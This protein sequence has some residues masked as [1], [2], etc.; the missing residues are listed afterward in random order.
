MSQRRYNP[1]PWPAMFTLGLL[2]L[3]LPALGIS[4]A[5]TNEKSKAPLFIY[6]FSSCISFLS[7]GYDKYRAT[8]RRWRLRENLLHLIDLLGGWPGGFAAQ[9]YFRHKTR[10]PS[11]QLTFWF[12]VAIHQYF[13]F[14]RLFPAPSQHFERLDS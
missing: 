6:S 5:W 2:S 13:I 4:Q 8:N 9:Y 1:K 3:V 11:F 10:K 14:S 12:T 7:Y